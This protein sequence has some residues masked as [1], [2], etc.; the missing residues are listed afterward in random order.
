MM[1]IELSGNGLA[2]STFIS[3]FLELSSGFSGSSK[4]EYRVEVNSDVQSCSLLLDSQ[5]LS[6]RFPD[7]LVARGFASHFEIG[8]C[9]CVLM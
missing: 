7:K 3:V 5:M 9:W 4:Y 1:L 8:E 6:Q 2:K